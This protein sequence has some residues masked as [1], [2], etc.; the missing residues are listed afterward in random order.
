[1]CLLPYGSCGYSLSHIALRLNLHGPPGIPVAGH[2]DED[3]WADLSKWET[4]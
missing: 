3:V 4:L 1:M 2:T